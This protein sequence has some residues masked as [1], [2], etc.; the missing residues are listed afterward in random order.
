MAVVNLLWDLALDTSVQS[1]N[2]AVQS[3][4]KQGTSTKSD[5]SLNVQPK[6]SDNFAWSFAETIASGIDTT[7]W[8]LVQKWSGMAVSQSDGNLVVTTGTTINSETIIRSLNTVQGRFRFEYLM[9][10]SQRIV[11]QNF[12]IEITDILWDWL[13]L[14]VNST[15]S[16]TVT[17]N[18]HGLDTAK[19][20][21]KQIS[22]CAISWVAAQPQ[23]ATIA[24]L[25]ANTITLTVVAFPSSGTW[26][27]TLYWLNMFQLLYNGA[28][29]TSMNAGGS[30]WV[31]VF[32]K[33]RWQ[34]VNPWINTT[35]SPWHIGIIDATKPFDIT[36]SDQ[37]PW[38]ATT[39]QSTPRVTHNQNIP[40]DTTPLYIQIRVFNGSTAPAS[41]TTMTLWFVRFEQANP[42]HVNVAGLQ[43]MGYKNALPVTVQS[44]P[45]TTVTWTVTATVANATMNYVLP[46]QVTD[47]ASGAITTT[48]TTAP[49][50]PT[51]GCSYSVQIP[52]TAVS[53][54]NPT[55]D[56]VV[57]ESF[58]WGT[59]WE[60]VYHFPRIT[61]IGNYTSPLLR[62]NWNRIRYIQT[63]GGTTPSFTRVIN[64]IQSNSYAPTL[65]Q[66]I[67]RTIVA[68]TLNSTTWSFL[69]RW[70]SL[71]QIQVDCGA[72]T[73]APVLVFEGSPD[74]VIWGN[75]A[76]NDATYTPTANILNKYSVWWY[77]PIL[78]Q[79]IRV[80]VWTA[81]ASATINAIYFIWRE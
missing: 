48:T 22:I 81:G 58:D 4:I 14:T 31:T 78:D 55:M 1:I 71:L 30:S 12:A 68:T 15:T 80:R 75:I 41:T 9:Q 19:S 43:P 26:T 57:Q 37:V 3:V 50:A 73:T 28:S 60:D 20:V 42:M 32:R 23:L 46:W 44:A 38:S 7:Y 11:N 6:I 17:K 35:A 24:S 79:Y 56:V 74:G 5:K 33:W 67:D 76:L 13:A 16:I 63:I 2:T 21:W 18:A 51:I 25:T 64:R 52:V 49:I 53:G 70:C 59:N 47:V 69:M 29:A 36:Y 65:R 54:T 66:K 27:C 40:D 61:A 10:L 62:L 45:T 77:S 39:I 8:T 72:M 34:W